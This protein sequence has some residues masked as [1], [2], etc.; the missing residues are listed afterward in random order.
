VLAR[1]GLSLV[2]Q[3]MMTRSEPPDHDAGDG[4]EE[5]RALLASAALAR[6]ST[7]AHDE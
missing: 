3:E 7:S 6:F 2:S 1:Q 5:R 4:A